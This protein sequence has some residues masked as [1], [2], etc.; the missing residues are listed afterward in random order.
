M[1]H[2]L[3]LRPPLLD[4][5]LLELAARV[6]SPWK[7]R[8]GETKWILKQAFQHQLPGSALFRPKQGFEIPVDA[9]LRGPL[10]EMFEAAVLQPQ[11]PVASLVSQ[12][13]AKRIYRAHLAGTGRHGSI[14]W[15][16][17]IL[18]RWS[19]RYLRCSSERIATVNT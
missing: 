9:W 4:H 14:L 1:A 17:L 3:E 11:A 7:V 18:A 19:E 16:L 2:G 12:A 6:P 15:S 8:N 10:R 13:A 5:E